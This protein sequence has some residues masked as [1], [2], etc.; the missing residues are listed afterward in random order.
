MYRETLVQLLHSRSAALLAV[1]VDALA[2][3]L[4]DGYC[5]VDSIGRRLPREQYLNSRR[6][7]ELRLITQRM[8]DVEVRDLGGGIAIVTAVTHDQGEFNDQAFRG[9]Y[10]VVHVC[11]FDGTKWLFVFGQSTTLENE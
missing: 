8:Q 2:A 5:Y 4:D 10:R 7:G 6:G 3:L 9:A 1:D 11:R